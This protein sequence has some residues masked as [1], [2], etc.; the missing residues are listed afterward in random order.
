[1]TGAGRAVAW[2]PV[3]AALA[4][5]Q[6][7]TLKAGP[8]EKFRTPCAAVQ[9][10]RPGDTIE[11][12]AGRY[13]G[14]VCAI[15]QD[16]LT[17]RAAG[18]PVRIDA[19]GRS[20]ADKGAW[21]VTGNGVTL[22]GIEF[23]GARSTAKNGSGIR[24]EGRN[25]TVRRCRFLD[26]EDG[27]LTAN[28]G[29]ELVVEYSEFGYNG[30]GDGQSHNIYAGRIDRFTMRFC[31]SH[32]AREGQ[33]VK[34]R[35][36]LSEILYN[37]LTEEPD[38]AG[39]YEID[40][41]NGGL[42]YVIGNLVSQDEAGPNGTLLTY[43]AEGPSAH[44]PVNELYVVHN[45]FVNR[46]KAGAIFVRVDPRMTGPVVLRNNIFDGPGVVWNGARAGLLG[47]WIGPADSPGAI[48]C[49]VEP[50]TGHGRDLRPESEY[51]HPASGRPRV[52]QGRPDA[53]AFEKGIHHQP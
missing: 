26:N 27:I 8:N 31:Y 7:R 4:S 25:L 17:L 52:P 24:M 45:T 1:M 47:N 32:H 44:A 35:A 15:P 46:R 40:L 22:E 51:V 43:M 53:G 48:D 50:G 23:R 41:S 19:A 11:I 21:V 30:A 16:R 37:R 28:S 13:E 9:A 14:D 36:A 39:S 6:G 5:G 38:G 29:G 3:A 2:L 18:G 49:G 42:A 10:A 20:H 12:A 34:S 33:L